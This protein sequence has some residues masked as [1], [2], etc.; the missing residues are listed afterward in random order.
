M[1]IT[2]K[3]KIIKNKMKME[4]KKNHL[5]PRMI[6]LIMKTKLIQGKIYS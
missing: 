4:R 5:I 6:Q 2:F 3:I 1:I